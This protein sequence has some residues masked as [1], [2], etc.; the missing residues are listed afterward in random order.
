MKVEMS[1]MT[2]VGKRYTIVIPKSVRKRLKVEE[3]QKVW[4]RAEGSAILVEPL[5]QDPYESLRRIVRRPYSEQKDERKAEEL[6]KKY[7]GARHRS[8]VRD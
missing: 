1:E 4:V 7:A 5:P 8:P 6:L 2:V 3:G